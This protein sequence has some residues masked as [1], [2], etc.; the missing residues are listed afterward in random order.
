[1][2]HQM[3]KTAVVKDLWRESSVIPAKKAIGT[4]LKRI[5]MDVKVRNAKRSTP[6]VSSPLDWIDK[7]SLLF[8]FSTNTF[9]VHNAM[10]QFQNWNMFFSELNNE[11]N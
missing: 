3:M 7:E 5:H 6:T 10:V 8:D 2:V 11:R 4:S 9:F 1:M